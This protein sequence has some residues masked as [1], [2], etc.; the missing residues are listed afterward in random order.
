MEYC[1]A[2][3][4]RSTFA[5]QKRLQK[6]ILCKFYYYD[7]ETEIKMYY[8]VLYPTFGSPDLSVIEKPESYVPQSHF[9]V[10]I[11]NLS[12]EL[13]AHFAKEEDLHGDQSVS[14]VREMIT[15]IST[16]DIDLLVS[17]T[18]VLIKFDSLDSIG[19]F[20]KFNRFKN[21]FYI[22]EY[23]HISEL[24]N[25]S[26]AITEYN[27]SALQNLNNCFINHLQ[28]FVEEV[29]QDKIQ[30]RIS[31]D[32][33]NQNL[34]NRKRYYLKCEVITTHKSFFEYFRL[35]EIFLEPQ[36]TQLSPN[37]KVIGTFFVL[38]T[39][40]VVYFVFKDIS[41]KKKQQKRRVKV[42]QQT[43]Y[44]EDDNK[45][46]RLNNYADDSVGAEKSKMLLSE[47]LNEDTN[48]EQEFDDDLSYEDNR[49]GLVSMKSSRDDLTDLS[50]SLIL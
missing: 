6:E 3:Y 16:T 17:R 40:V 35:N 32:K 38:L 29:K 21:K 14:T 23:V 31:G 44:T 2:F 43:R 15:R 10:G 22:N 20:M 36:V 11:I 18:S 42:Y 48:Q 25:M 26:L 13:V 46:R 1:A 33:Q 24:K 50:S 7:R 12:L 34:I 4:D 47:W 49:T 30:S 9:P 41:G 27:F 28:G 5:Q 45:A 39:T 19:V 8:L 37:A